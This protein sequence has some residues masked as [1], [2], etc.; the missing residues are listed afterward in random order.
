MSITG[1]PADPNRLPA[2]PLTSLDEATR[3]ITASSLKQN[4][5]RTVRVLNE[6]RFLSVLERM[7]EDRIRERL[8][9][10]TAEPPPGA[11]G[12]TASRATTREELMARWEH[13]RV[14]YE[15]KLRHLE[16]RLASLAGGR[17]PPAQ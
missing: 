12:G 7:V 14:R 8:V 3:R 9:P 1:N 4:G 17:S 13:F 5:V 2:D 15:E 11:A 6:S 10:E 16:S